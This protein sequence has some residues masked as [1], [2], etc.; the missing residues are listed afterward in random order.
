MY[1]LD[2]ND[3]HIVG[4]SP[5]MLVRV[6]DEIATTNPIAGTRPRGNTEQEDNVN[7][8]ELLE[9]EKERA[10]HVMLVDLGRND[11]G[12][13]SEP[14]TV[15]VPKFMEVE[16]YSHVMHI[17][18]TVTGKLKET[19]TSFDALRSCF[20]AGTLSGA[21]KVRAIEIIN[22]QEPHGRGPYGGAVGYFSHSG[23][24]DMAI[25]IRTVI[26]KDGVATVQAGAG[27]VY[28]SVPETEYEESL[29]KARGMLNAIDGAED[30]TKSRL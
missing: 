22:D 27:L 29:H 26:I 20:P 1:Y 30:L 5:E 18:S 14:G 6:E 19:L 8:K 3:Y 28:D 21:P 13:V 11:I 9:D 2:F 16:L 12:K 17:V 4:T 7:A 15:T 24:M 25:C 23:N 10:E